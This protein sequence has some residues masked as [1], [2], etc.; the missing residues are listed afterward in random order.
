[1]VRC[2]KAVFRKNKGLKV[3]AK[4]YKTHLEKVLLPN[5]DSMMKRKDWIFIQNSAPSR[6][7]NL[8]QDFLSEKLNKR[9][10]KYSEWPPT[11]PDCS[12]VDYHFWEK[13]QRKVYENR[14]NGAFDNENALKRRIRRVWPKVSRDIEEIRKALKEFV[15]RLKSVTEKDGQCIKMLFGCVGK[16]SLCN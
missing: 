14:F 11:S 13:V 3:N 9:F 15:P 1:M 6:R 10:V 8:V 7:A 12:P 5:I 4:R 16:R 2:H